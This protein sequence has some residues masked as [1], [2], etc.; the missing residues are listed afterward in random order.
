MSETAIKSENRWRKWLRSA[1]AQKTLVGIIFLTIPL[2]LLGLFT[3]YPLAK[4]VEYSF[5]NMGYLGG[6]TY[7]GLTNYVQIIKNEGLTD[8]WAAFRN[9][10]Y[11]MGGAV[12][13]LILALFFATALS[14]RTRGAS[15]FKG[16]IFFPYLLCGIAVGFVFKYFFKEGMVLDTL[17]SVLHIDTS[18][19]DLPE[20][21]GVEGWLMNTKIN[22]ICLV[23]TSV[24]RYL[25]QNMV[26]FIGA[27]MSVDPNLYEAA[28]IDG[29]NQFH[30]FIH[31]IMPSIKTII[32]LNLILSITGSLCAFEPPF[33]ITGGGAG[34][35]TYFTLMNKLAHQGASSKVGKAAAMAVILLSIIFVVTILQ[36][37][38]FKIAF[39]DDNDSGIV[40]NKEK[41]D[42]QLAKKQ[43]K[44]RAK[45]SVDIPDR[46][47]TSEKGGDKL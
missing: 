14:F 33:V 8:Y 23:F 6:K 40:R 11:Y 45:Y 35:D 21:L 10:F 39:R 29:A 18:W 41:Y 32:M 12:I 2:I 36:K 5:Y 27:I 38:I 20:T 25:G 3:Y 46:V 37:I 9:S 28:E 44:L 34:T 22:N 16:F 4:M 13:Q 1:R 30:K 47:S 17:C 15:I 19:V 24:W 43:Q 7:V 31:I 26:L 42:K